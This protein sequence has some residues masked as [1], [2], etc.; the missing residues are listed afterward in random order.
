MHSPQTGQPAGQFVDFAALLA[1]TQEMVTAQAQ[2]GTA[3]L[4]S[5]PDSKHSVS[6]TSESK[7]LAA[8]SRS[9]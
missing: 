5:S 1:F 7:S 4:G 8:R 9:S 2:D 3:A 6:E